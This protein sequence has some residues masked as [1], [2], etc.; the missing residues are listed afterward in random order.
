MKQDTDEG[1][2]GSILASGDIPTVL[3]VP[4]E[5]CVDVTH[6]WAEGLRLL[7]HVSGVED[8]LGP[9]PRTYM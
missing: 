9:L 2:P 6:I 1:T 4:A 8:G 5:V 3:R 7:G